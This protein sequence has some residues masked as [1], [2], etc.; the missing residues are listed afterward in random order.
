M[1]QSA[2][3]LRRG[4]ETKVGLMFLYSLCY[5]SG[6]FVIGRSISRAL[7]LS[8]LPKEAIAYRFILPPLVIMLVT[9]WYT[10]LSKRYSLS[11]LILGSNALLVVGVLLFRLLLETTYEHSFTLLVTMYIFFEV[12]VLLVGTQFWAFAGEVF[13]PRQAKRL[14]GLISV[15]GTVA[16]VVGGAG[17][18]LL[19]TMLAPKN[20]IFILTACLAGSMGCVWAL[21]REEKDQKPSSGKVETRSAPAGRKKS[22]LWHDLKALRQSPLLVSI[23]SI[24]LLLVVMATIAEY[25]L[26][27]ALKANF[28]N[29]AGQISAFLGAFFFGSGLV[30]CIIQFLVTGRVLARYG[31]T[32]AL[33]FSPIGY[34]LGAVAMLLSGGALWATA[35]PRASDV[36]FRTT[37]NSAATNMLYLPAPA[38]LRQ[39]AKTLVQGFITPPMIILMGLLFFFLRQV[40]GITVWH[41]AIPMLMLV[42][43][44]LYLIFRARRQY[45]E[46]LAANLKKF[47]LALDESALDLNDETTVQLL[48]KTL[49]HPDE[50]Q[51]ISA[52]RLLA[53][54]PQLDWLLHLKPLLNHPS[55]EVRV[56]A[57]KALAGLGGQA[58][59][60]ALQ[61]LCRAP[62]EAVRTMAIEAYCTLQKEQALPYVL[63]FLQ[64]ASPGTKR[65]ALVG[66]IRYGGLDGM[67]PAVEQLKSM[68]ASPQAEMRLE[69]ARALGA[70]EIRTFYQ[71]LITL[72]D[73]PQ[74]T[75][76]IEAIRAAGAVKAPALAPYLIQKLGQPATRLAAREA[77]VQIGSPIEPLLAQTLADSTQAQAI[78]LQLPVVLQHLGTAQAAAILLDHLKEG[79]RVVRGA[80][81]A[82][83]TRLRD[84]G[85]AFEV[86][87]ELLHEALLLEFGYYYEVYTWRAE[88]NGAEAGTVTSQNQVNLLEEAL[89][90]R[91]NERLDRIFFLLEL[92]HSV[93]TI[94]A[95]RQ[96]L[97]TKDGPQRANAI[98]LLDNVIGREVKTLLLPLIEAPVEQVLALARQHFQIKR[99]TKIE[100]LGELAGY[101]DPWLRSCAI[102][103]IGRLGPPMLTEPVLAALHSEHALVR[104][105]AL[106]AC[107]RLIDEAQF[108]QILI[109][110]AANQERYAQAWLQQNR[111]TK[112]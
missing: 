22:S 103:E 80:I 56:T 102:F 34:A 85:V 63:P 30:A 43:L 54:A 59:A 81:F 25:Q 1:L 108:A 101:P 31:I 14:F 28:S 92:L 65:A 29:D 83:L 46:S 35:L 5:V 36:M 60:E 32:A 96:T 68:L 110:Q 70:L 8:S 71:P 2:L 33:L 6:V 99:L 52:L 42:G 44:W 97:K 62:E 105:T 50:L 90:V 57:I 55:V 61:S 112:K 20:L 39:Q 69:A 41:W 45:T 77:L 17:L 73:D 89:T 19:A 78:R 74:P 100:R 40:E 64:E 111:L 76:Q 18:G 66:L 4:E 21:R 47:R 23:S 107:R 13:D 49:Q 7:F 51:V 38:N 15:G 16:N 98:E 87:K 26:D 109:T 79:D 58:E 53:E 88:L 11:Q 10:R 9:L 104:E 72:F 84:A 82:A 3:N 37:I 67:L 27:L 106:V 91:L 48:I 12:M 93:P 86:K 75:I 24:A 95:I 94:D